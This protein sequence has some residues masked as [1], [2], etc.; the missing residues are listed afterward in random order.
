MIGR[1]VDLQRGDT[2]VTSDGTEWAL[3]D[4]EL[5]REGVRLHVDGLPFPW[6]YGIAE[7]VCF[8]RVAVTG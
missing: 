3:A 1:A 5:V 8:M 7:L 4:V 6:L 2:L